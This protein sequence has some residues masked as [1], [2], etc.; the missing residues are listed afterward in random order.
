MTKLLERGIEAVEALSPDRQD[1]AG[2]LLLELAG[3]AT[4]KYALTPE[5]IEDLKAAIAEADRG[6]FATDEEMRGGLADVR[7]MKLRYTPRAPPPRRS[8]TTSPNAVLRPLVDVG[9]RIRETL[10]MLA[11]FPDVGHRGRLNGHARIRRP[12]TALRHRVSR[13][14]PAR[15][16]SPIAR[17]LSR[18]AA[19][20]AVRAAPT[21]DRST[22]DDVRLIPPRPSASARRAPAIARAIASVMKRAVIGVP[23]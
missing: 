22:C 5:Q 19:A 15:R 13:R 11:E 23:S 8:P 4:P 1:I 17:R 20:A 16:R 9:R 2:E 21:D 12:G 18:R 14:D 3:D 7:A 6:E 10:S